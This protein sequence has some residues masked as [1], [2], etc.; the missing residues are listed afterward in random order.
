[1]LLEGHESTHPC[2]VPT[3]QHRM[4]I[5][6][7]LQS[8]LDGTTVSMPENWDAAKPVQQ[9]GAWHSQHCAQGW[10]FRCKQTRTRDSGVQH[11]TFL[12]AWVTLAKRSCT[13]RQS[14]KMVRGQT[15]LSRRGPSCGDDRW[16]DRHWFD[17]PE[18][19]DIIIC[20]VA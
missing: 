10:P 11:G 3:P 1:M 12:D 20:D 6:G 17:L 19:N 5:D 16:G 14:A 15:H 4:L 13:C 7:F 8:A 9:Q 18:H 2:A